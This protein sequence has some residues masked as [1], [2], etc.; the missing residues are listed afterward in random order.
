MVR[1]VEFKA[2]RIGGYLQ[3]MEQQVNLKLSNKDL[4]PA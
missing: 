4:L 1:P 3:I 2:L